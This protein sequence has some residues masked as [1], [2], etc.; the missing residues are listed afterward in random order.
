MKLV[1]MFQHSGKE[2]KVDL[3]KAVENIS[4]LHLDLLTEVHLILSLKT[5]SIKVDQ[6]S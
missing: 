6:K 4:F 5:I 3:F 1:L 2:I